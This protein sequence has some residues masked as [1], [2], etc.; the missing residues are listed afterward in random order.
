MC[1]W[2]SYTA[3]WALTGIMVANPAIVLN[4]ETLEENYRP[5]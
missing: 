1:V 2:P 3:D 4:N 5:G